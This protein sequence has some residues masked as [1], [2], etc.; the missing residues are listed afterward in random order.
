MSH[1]T[2]CA[3]AITAL[4]LTTYHCIYLRA[5][6]AQVQYQ[7][8][9]IR[10]ALELQGTVNDNLLDSVKNLHSCHVAVGG[11]IESLDKRI[12]AIYKYGG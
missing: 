2:V 4:V 6:L 3:I 11:S 8:N 12:S 5:R 9:H 10:E 1:E 7:L